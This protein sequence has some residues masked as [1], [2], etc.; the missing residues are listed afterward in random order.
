MFCF[1]YNLGRDFVFLFRASAS[2]MSLTVENNIKDRSTELK[3]CR[4]R[5]FEINKCFRKEQ[6]DNKQIKNLEKIC[7]TICQHLI[8]NNNLRVKFFCEDEIIPLVYEI[9]LNHYFENEPEG[10]KCNL[11]FEKMFSLLVSLNQGLLSPVIISSGLD[12]KFS[13]DIVKQFVTYDGFENNKKQIIN[14][15]TG[16]V[17]PSKELQKCFSNIIEIFRDNKVKCLDCFC[18][19]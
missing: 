5:L 8:K 2:Q 18:V 19:F 16:P 4:Q 3:N 6:M 17:Q 7:E 11:H 10:E 1:N 14:I 9:N 12:L 13:Q 15:H